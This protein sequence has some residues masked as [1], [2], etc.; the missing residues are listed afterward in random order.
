VVGR[1]AR[2]PSTSRDAVG[3]TLGLAWEK[4][5]NILEAGPREI[6]LSKGQASARSANWAAPHFLV[7]L[8]WEFI[9]R[10]NIN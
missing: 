8:K 6:L 4:K 5:G 7:H 9:K 2:I 1:A 10:S 3:K